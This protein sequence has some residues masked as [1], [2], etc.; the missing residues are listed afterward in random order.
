MIPRRQLGNIEVVTKRNFLHDKSHIYR[1]GRE[2][3]SPKVISQFLTP[4]LIHGQQMSTEY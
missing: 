4:E 3:R 1:Y 2:P